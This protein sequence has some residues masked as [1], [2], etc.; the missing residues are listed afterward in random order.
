MQSLEERTGEADVIGQAKYK[1]KLQMLSGRRLVARYVAISKNGSL[2]VFQDEKGG[3]P[4]MEMKLDSTTQLAMIEKLKCGFQVQSGSTSLIFSA[5]DEMDMTMWTNTIL[6]LQ[7]A[8]ISDYENQT[9]D[10]FTQAQTCLE[11]IEM[12]TNRI[13]AHAEGLKEQAKLIAKIAALEEMVRERDSEITKLKE[14]Q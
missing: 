10:S 7:V 9:S 3:K 11:Q 13:T 14:S 8:G 1:G 4:Q 2:F 5:A 12:Y 6:K